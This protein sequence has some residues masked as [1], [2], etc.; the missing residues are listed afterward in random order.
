MKTIFETARFGLPFSDIKIVD[1]HAHFGSL[2]Q[3]FIPFN[4]LPEI[5]ENMNRIGIDRTCFCTQPYGGYGDQSIWNN[6]LA[7]AV[8]KYPDRLSG[9]VTLNGN[10]K[11]EALEEFERGERGG[12]T[13][14]LKMHTVRQDYSVT[15]KFLY[16]IYEKMDFRHAWYLHHDF[17]P[18][19]EF[20]QLLCD[21]PNII[22][23]Q[24]HPSLQYQRLVRKY[25]N[26]Y[27]STCAG[28]QYRQVEEM[29]NC[30][31]AEKLLMGSDSVIFDPTFGIAP[32]AFADISEGDKRK[33]LGENAVRLLED[34]R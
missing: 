25:P 6:R 29:V 1:V 21:F 31:G 3:T 10:W 15:D 20:E 32:I 9:Y 22:F 33:I 13:L 34:I 16:P 30:V 7:D 28:L 5:L 26:F 27:I 8:S 19:K 4:T 18:E 11:D 17:G 12:L 23:I 24:G 2:I 14:G